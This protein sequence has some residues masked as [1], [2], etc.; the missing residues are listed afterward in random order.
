MGLLRYAFTRVLLTIPMVLILLTVVFLVLHVMPGN[1]VLVILGGRNVPLALIKEYE[2]RLGFDQPIY[3][4]Y[5]KYL[6]GVVHGN[7]GQSF[8]SGLPVSSQIAL[9]LPATLELSFS[10]LFIAA[11]IGV[12]TGIWASLRRGGMVDQVLRFTHIGTYAIPIFWSGLM[13]QMVFG[14]FLKWFPTGLQL[15]PV[16]AAF[17]Q[18]IT[19][20]VVLDTVL[21]GNWPLLG[22][23]LLHLLLPAFTLGLALSG[24]V[25]R[26]TRASMLEVLDLDYVRTARS[27]G[28]PGRATVLK[29]AL[30]NALIP[31]ITVV[32]IQ[33]AILMGG[34]VLTE[35]VFSWPGIGSFLL[36]SIKARD[37][38]AIQ[39]TVVVI[40]VLIATVNL[41]VDLCYALVDPRVR[42][43]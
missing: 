37:F 33:F 27:K 23:A 2:H 40:A 6:W 16:D 41:V 18:P 42:F 9:H 36:Q 32:G 13:L 35:A 3:V 31:I 43:S 8:S 24:L 7:L 22:E 28:L 15:N 4:Q 12:S 14:I 38:N 26:V 19:G 29:H 25:G 34:A 1:P 21:R 20:F 30:R 11:L 17:F 10:G 5:A 39:G